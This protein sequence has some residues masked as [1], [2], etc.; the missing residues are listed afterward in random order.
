MRHFIMI[1]SGYSVPTERQ[2]GVGACSKDSAFSFGRVF[3]YDFELDF[4]A[5]SIE[6]C[7]IGV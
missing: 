3:R 2:A 6:D 5:S 4:V 7:N 1:N